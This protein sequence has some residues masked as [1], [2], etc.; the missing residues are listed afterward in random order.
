MFTLLQAVY[1][2]SRGFTING[3]LH[4]MRDVTF[5]PTGMAAEKTK[6]VDR[7]VLTAAQLKTE[8][9]KALDAATAES[10]N[11]LL[12]ELWSLIL[13]FPKENELENKFAALKDLSLAAEATF[14]SLEEKLQAAHGEV[15]NKYKLQPG[16]KLNG[17]KFKIIYEDILKS[18][19]QLNVQ[20]QDLSKFEWDAIPAVVKEEN[21][22]EAK[23]AALRD[24]A[25]AEDA[26]YKSAEERLQ[27]AIEKA[28][29]KHKDLFF[30][31]IKL[32]E[33]QFRAVFNFIIDSFMRVN[34]NSQDLSSFEWNNLPDVVRDY[35]KN[36]CK[37]DEKTY[38]K[39]LAERIT[40]SEQ[41]V[42]NKGKFFGLKKSFPDDVNA[43]ISLLKGCADKLAT[44]RDG[45]DEK[46]EGIEALKA[47]ESRL[48]DFREFF[49]M[50]LGSHYILVD[51]VLKSH[52][53]QVN[54]NFVGK[55]G[56]GTKPVPLP[57]T[58]YAVSHHISQILIHSDWQKTERHYVG[59]F[60]ILAFRLTKVNDFFDNTI[61]R[62]AEFHLNA[63]CLQ[64][65]NNLNKI[66]L[67]EDQIP[68][69]EQSLLPVMMVHGEIPFQKVKVS[70]DKSESGKNPKEKK[71]KETK[72]QSSKDVELGL[73]K[74]K[75]SEG[76]D[77]S[78]ASAESTSGRRLLSRNLNLSAIFSSN[79]SPREIKK[80]QEV[81]SSSSVSHSA[82]SSPS[83]TSPKP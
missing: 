45:K 23:F 55:T 34:A 12:R 47:I 33:E 11:K 36:I 74:G 41:Y 6:L 25:R 10:K 61:T 22:I 16:D 76:S 83:P 79:S 66:L 54:S 8:L 13:G 35:L 40:T 4:S 49:K 64:L 1:R 2:V 29:N 20:D 75:S 77:S 48:I 46:D 78:S 21:D 71:K 30:P 72:K 26:K 57:S 9:A 42:R 60:E 58:V 19:Q 67:K 14:Q 59:T 50:R 56:T 65:T 62:G 27:K 39:W 17:E 81:V 51:D 53:S 80:V 43:Y 63:A 82:S 31:G 18:L 32:N 15:T 3:D 38:K 73:P 44:K 70:K 5:G 52:I 7:P 24:L 37:K 68:V 28:T 69:K